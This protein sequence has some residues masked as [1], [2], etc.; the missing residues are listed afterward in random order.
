M[1]LL[2]LL[3]ISAGAPAWAGQSA[4]SKRCNQL[5]GQCKSTVT[6]TTRTKVTKTR[7]TKEPGTTGAPESNPQQGRSQQ[8]NAP[9]RALTEAEKLAI[10][11]EEFRQE[12]LGMPP[13]RACGQVPMAPCPPAQATPAQ[14]AV[15]D[16]PGRTVTTTTVTVHEVV[17]QAKAKIKLPKPKIGSAPC[18]DVGCKGTVGVPTWFWL[19]DDEWRT[20]TDSASAGGTSVTVTAKP[21]KVVWSLGDGQ[22]VTC[23]GPGTEYVESMGWATSPD[24]GIATGYKEAGTYTITAELTYEVTVSGDATETETLTR[25]SSQDVTVGELQSV[26]VSSG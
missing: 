10:R 26:V 17:E 25:S 9:S 13:P 3:I 1:V 4:V 22:S 15:P 24:C 2:T 11:Q 6:E 18:T 14:A 5:T 7:T 12:V 8:V 23:T 19:D 20:R 21:S 16:A